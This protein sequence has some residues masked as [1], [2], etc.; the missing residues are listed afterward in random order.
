MINLSTCFGSLPTAL[1]DELVE[2][3]KSITV[4]YRERR[5]EPAE[6][7]GGKLC[8]IVYSII[9]GELSGSYPPS[10]KKPRNM[11][12]AC[13]AVEQ[14]PANANRVGD[15]SLR[16]LIPRLLPYLYE[17]RNNRGV[18]HV[19]GDVDPNNADAESVMAMANWLMAELIRIF[20]GISI[21]EAQSIIEVIVESRHPLVWE[22]DGIRRVLD[23]KMNK[24]SQTLVLLYGASGWTTV[25]D[26]FSWVEYSSLSSYK[27]NVLTRLHKKRRVEYDFNAER[28]RLTPLGSIEVEGLL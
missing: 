12:S 15:R 16:I 11:V 24:T 28:V 4:N 13:R 18:G 25:D 1:K 23:P 3:Y 10:S 26:L 21:A 27:T 6:L 8:E 19:G 22:A 20:H 2:C 5:W 14:F 9:E 7:N 17:I